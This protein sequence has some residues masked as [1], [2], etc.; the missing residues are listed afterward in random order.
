MTVKR[1]PRPPHLDRSQARSLLLLPELVEP[2]F[3]L[4][5]LA[6]S[7]QACWEQVHRAFRDLADGAAQTKDAWLPKLA[8][9]HAYRARLYSRVAGQRNELLPTLEHS[10]EAL[11]LLLS[12]RK[13]QQAFLAFTE[14]TGLVRAAQSAGA[15]QVVTRHLDYC[16]RIAK[17]SQVCRFLLRGAR[18]TQEVV[19]ADP[20][21]LRHEHRFALEQ[22]F[23][24]LE[25]GARRPSK[26]P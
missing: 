3:W 2:D 7:C 14:Y 21:A 26:D 19:A 25:E 8:L 9:A 6:Q 17:Q 12:L 15:E 13:A 23:A 11:E 22:L 20:E 1:P 18:K 10:R 24:E 4:Q 5:H 16:R